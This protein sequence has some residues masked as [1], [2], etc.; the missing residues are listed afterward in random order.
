M[1]R[2]EFAKRNKAIATAILKQY[3]YRPL[4]RYYD[5]APSRIREITIAT[6]RRANP[7]LF[8]TCPEGKPIIA[9]LREHADEFIKSFSGPWPFPHPLIVMSHE[10]QTANGNSCLVHDI[11]ECEWYWARREDG[12]KTTSQ[13]FSSEEEAVEA[14]SSD[15]LEW[16]PVRDC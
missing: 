14:Q 12:I 7:E 15:L 3:P 2:N 9:Y 1:P 8:K 11:K 10:E 16:Y 4:A 6:C 13:G 5:V